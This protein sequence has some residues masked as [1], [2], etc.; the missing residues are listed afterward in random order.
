MADFSLI[1]RRKQLLK[2]LGFT[3]I[4]AQGLTVAP[5]VVGWVMVVLQ[6]WHSDRTRLVEILHTGQSSN[7]LLQ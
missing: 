4:N 3:A 5:Y 1:S 6:A 7:P 2:N